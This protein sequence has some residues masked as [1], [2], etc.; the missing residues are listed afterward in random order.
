MGLIREILR[1]PK[2]SEEYDVVFW[3]N[4]NKPGDINT[5]ILEAINTSQYGVCYLSEK[6]EDAPPG[7]PLYRDNTNVVF[8]A[9]MLY[10][11]TNDPHAQPDHWL[12]IRE[13]DSTG[14]P[15]DFATQR[16]LLVPRFDDGSLNENSFRSGLKDRLAGLLKV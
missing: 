14:V 2:Y 12:L 16:I 8:E 10:A 3:E 1:D 13:Q 5:H 6:I 11:L 4:I 15:F 9:G 7:T